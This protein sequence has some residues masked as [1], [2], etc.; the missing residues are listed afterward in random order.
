MG[1]ISAF[2]VS[3]KLGSGASRVAGYGAGCGHAGAGGFDPQPDSTS[4]NPSAQ[5]VVLMLQPRKVL[6]GVRLALLRG[7][8]LG[9]HLRDST[10][11]RL[12]LRGAGGSLAA[13][14]VSVP[15][16]ALRVPSG[17]KRYRQ[18]CNGQRGPPL[19]HAVNSLIAA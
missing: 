5:I 14:Y 16:Q 8:S 12:G 9:G 18:G 11:R 19:D 10:V 2:S 3:I 6:N 17:A 1:E 13:R 7:D 4:I 15:A